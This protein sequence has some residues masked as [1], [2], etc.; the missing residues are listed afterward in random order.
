MRKR[1][2][3]AFV[4][5]EHGGWAMLLIPLA[6]AMLVRGVSAASLCFTAFVL[7]LFF[8]RQPLAM[9][10][11]ANYGYRVDVP[12]G[13]LRAATAVELTF[14]LAV[15]TGLAVLSPAPAR[16]WLLAGGLAAAAA[17]FVSALLAGRLQAT[18][19]ASEWLAVIGATL[20]APAYGLALGQP[21]GIDWLLAFYAGG[22]FACSLTRVR[23][24]GRRRNDSRY[25]WLTVGWHVGLLA[26]AIG[27]TVWLAGPLTLPLS[28]LLPAL[29]AVAFAA[30]AVASRP[31]PRVGWIEV[32]FS[33]V[34][35]TLLVIGGKQVS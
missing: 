22:Y 34:F 2:V 18:S 5:Q 30:R 13:P 29:W 9:L 14:A 15:L 32:V 11:R 16:L 20:L 6:A 27:L 23:A 1:Y 12:P 10:Y 25:R 17:L 24:Q 35:L 4:P 3:A 7:L 21:A 19:A 8:A 31:L 26:L 28:L 33:V